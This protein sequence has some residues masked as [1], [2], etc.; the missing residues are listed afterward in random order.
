MGLIILHG[1]PCYF[2]GCSSLLSQPI[3]FSVFRGSGPSQSKHW[4][5][6]CPLPSGGSARIKYAPQLGQVG[7]ADSTHDAS[8]DIRVPTHELTRARAVL[9]IRRRI[10]AAKPDWALSVTGLASLRG[11]GGQ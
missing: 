11:R 7:R 3:A 6:R 8:M 4:N 1:A 5:L 2:G 10:A 9:R